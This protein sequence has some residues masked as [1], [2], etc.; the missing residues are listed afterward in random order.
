MELLIQYNE[1]AIGH[2]FRIPNQPNNTVYYKM[3]AKKVFNICNRT[4]EFHHK[5]NEIEDLGLTYSGISIITFAEVPI[6]N[7]FQFIGID[8]KISTVFKKIDFT[9]V[10]TLG[11]PTPSVYRK[12]NTLVLQLGNDMSDFIP[13]ML[14]GG[15][16]SESSQ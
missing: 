15:T 3:S 4:I 5:N 11:D 9:K 8:S 7:Y 10:R 16:K 6:D 2:F 12:K 1:L 13:P 14:V